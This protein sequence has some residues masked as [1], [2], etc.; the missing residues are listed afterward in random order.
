MIYFIQAKQFVKIGYSNDPE[1]CLKDL[2][3][4]NPVRL[5]LLATMPGSYQT[6]AELHKI[7]EKH[8]ANLEWFRYD[9]H[10]KN[11]IR[12]INDTHNIHP[13]I[14]VRS[15][16]KA[17]LHLHLRIKASRLKCD[18]RNNKLFLKI[19]KNKELKQGK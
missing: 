4:A 19:E 3:T 14:D 8:R 10:L 15:L 2:Q 5:K 17:G 18:N 7:F 13:V 11:C 9:G 1:N 12:A 16:Q 6:E